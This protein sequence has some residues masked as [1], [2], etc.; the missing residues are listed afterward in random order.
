MDELW[1][2]IC[3][4][5]TSTLDAGELLNKR[6]LQLQVWMKNHVQHHVVHSFWHQQDVMSQLPEIEA[7]VQA[8][9]ITPGLAADVL[10]ER[11][12]RQRIS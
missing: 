3:Q 2:S 11:F 6:K 9:R 7:M 1:N 8:G 5:K 4:Y 10:L 12:F